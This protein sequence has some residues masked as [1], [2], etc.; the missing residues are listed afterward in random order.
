M[1]FVPDA[2]CADHPLEVNN[3]EKLKFS[4]KESV[5]DMQEKKLKN[6]PNTSMKT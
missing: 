5:C 1:A 3:P 4:S 6:D 2:L